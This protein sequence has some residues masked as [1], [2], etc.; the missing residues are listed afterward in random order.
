MFDAN[1]YHQQATT[2]R[3]QKFIEIIP[4]IE[5]NYD[6]QTPFIVTA[7]PRSF[8][9]RRKGEQG[10]RNGGKEVVQLEPFT[11]NST[12]SNFRIIQPIKIVSIVSPPR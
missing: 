2:G 10:R 11:I 7:T 12:P 9:V 6:D 3:P 5:D 8:N 1:A 4:D